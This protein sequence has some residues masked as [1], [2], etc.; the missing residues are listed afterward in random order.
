MSWNAGPTILEGFWLLPTLIVQYRT[1]DSAHGSTQRLKRSFF[2]HYIQKIAIMGGD[3][4]TFFQEVCNAP[5]L[6]KF[7]LKVTIFFAYAM[8]L[9][10]LVMPPSPPGFVL[11][12]GH[13]AVFRLTLSA[14]YK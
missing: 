5:E 12:T 14:A 7:Q 11:R 8:L 9:E 3:A 13:A 1:V 2:L 4:F 10:N 6:R